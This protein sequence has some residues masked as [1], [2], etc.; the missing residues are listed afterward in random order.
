MMTSGNTIGPSEI[1]VMISDGFK[2]VRLPQATDSA[3]KELASRVELPNESR[4]AVA[5]LAAVDEEISP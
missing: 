4:R 1:P 5:T 3:A 2:P